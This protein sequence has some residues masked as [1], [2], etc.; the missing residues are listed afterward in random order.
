LY[1]PKEP[2]WLWRRIRE[3]RP[4]LQAVGI[5]T[6]QTRDKKHKQITLRKTKN[7]GIDGTNGIDQKNQLDK[8][9]RQG[10]DIL[11]NKNDGTDDGTDKVLKNRPV[12]TVPTYF[13]LMG[14]SIAKR[15]KK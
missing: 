4:N 11:K 15:K 1:W 2:R 8:R 5:E 6:E 14:W 3:V 13:P 10:A 9:C 12:P 7:D